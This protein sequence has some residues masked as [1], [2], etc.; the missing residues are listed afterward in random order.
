MKKILFY[1]IPL[2]MLL[3]L[4]FSCKK[5]DEPSPQT[6]YDTLKINTPYTSYTMAENTI[7]SLDATM[8]GATA[9]LWM[10]GNH[11]TAMIDITQE[12]YYTVKI[13]THDGEYNYEVLIL[14]NGSDCYIPNSFSPNGDGVNDNWRPLFTD[15]SEENY[16]LNIYD[17]DNLK[18]F[19]STE[20]TAAWDGYYHGILM[21]AAYYYYALSYQTLSGES[22]SRNGMIQ[23]VQ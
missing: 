13:S 10:P 6:L 20:N 5:Q 1:V 16:S 4:F 7:L 11:T 2:S 9:Y 21:P 22:K 18:L 3:L 8:S 19:S 12:G 17:N 23:L 14:Y 15:I